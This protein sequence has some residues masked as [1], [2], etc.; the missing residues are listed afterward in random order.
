MTRLNMAADVGADMGLFFPR[1][2]EEMKAGL[3]RTFETGTEGRCWHTIP[4]L[5]GGADNADRL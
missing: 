2:D 3:R 1:N 5:A 4:K